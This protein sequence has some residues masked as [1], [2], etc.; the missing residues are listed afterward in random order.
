[1]DGTEIIDAV[2]KSNIR[3]FRGIIINRF[4]RVVQHT[5]CGIINKKAQAKSSAKIGH[6]VCYWKDGDKKYYFDSFGKKPPLKLIRY[7]GNNV[8]YNKISVQNYDENIC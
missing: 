3:N 1:M 5:E 6:W 4:P 7:L 8:V 2:N